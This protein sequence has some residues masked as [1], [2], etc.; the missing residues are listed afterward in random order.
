MNSSPNRDRVYGQGH[1]AQCSH[2]VIVSTDGAI[3]K[4]KIRKGHRA[5]NPHHATD[6][7][8]GQHAYRKG[9]VVCNNAAPRMT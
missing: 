3:R 9:H 8:K 2:A 5:G 4:R 1:C 6:K 7:L